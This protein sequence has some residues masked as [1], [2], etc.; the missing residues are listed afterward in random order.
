MLSKM[1]TRRKKSR[2]SETMNEDGS[3]RETHS[4]GYRLRR[5]CSAINC[6]RVVQTKGLCS[7]HLREIDERHQSP[8]HMSMDDIYSADDGDSNSEEREDLDKKTSRNHGKLQ[9]TLVWGL[10]QLHLV[11]IV[12]LTY[13]GKRF[14]KN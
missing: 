2:T 7:Q 14:P 9:V 3:K 11:E 12:F 10:A 4:S 1:E 6:D 5:L 13:L 8:S